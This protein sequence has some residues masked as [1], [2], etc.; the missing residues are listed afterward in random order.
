MRKKIQSI[1]DGILGAQNNPEI[2]QRMSAYGYTP[3]RL[4]EGENLLDAVKSKRASQVAEYGNQYAATGELEKLFTASYGE[5]MVTVKVSRVALK[6]QPELLAKFKATGLRNRSLSGWLDDAGIFYTN[7]LETPEAVAALA[8][9]GITEERLRKE[10]ASV[11]EVENLHSRQLSEKGEAQQATKDRDKL[12]D[13][14]CNWY[15]DFRAIARIALYDKPQL[16]EA[17]GIV[18]K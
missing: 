8:A 7:L 3:E 9:F 12:F 4:A 13:Q 2:L 17:L 14:V 10:Q 5:Y 1:E 6:S 18:K 16:L 11:K 15:S